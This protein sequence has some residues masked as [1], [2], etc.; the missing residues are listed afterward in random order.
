[1]HMN[2][3]T[4]K[5]FL[6]PRV[7]EFVSYEY[8]ILFARHLTI[9]I[10]DLSSRYPEEIQ[11]NELRL[12]LLNK[13]LST[14]TE[15]EKNKIETELF[16]LRRDILVRKSVKQTIRSGFTASKQKTTKI[17][18]NDV[19]TWLKPGGLDKLSQLE[20]INL[21]SALYL[22]LY[23]TPEDHLK[24]KLIN[25]LSWSLKYTYAGIFAATLLAYKY[26]KKKKKTNI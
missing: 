24:L 6:K 18:V 16:Q 5:E 15:D 7:L 11:H 20:R 14:L 9:D 25:K 13:I 26:F 23:D 21:M 4:I 8:K 10:Y 2:I 17:P 1:M 3:A 12:K 22:D 19:L